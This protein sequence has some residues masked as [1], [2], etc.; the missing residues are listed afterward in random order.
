MFY[1]TLSAGTQI[2]IY[3]RLKEA[4]INPVIRKIF[5][6]WAVFWIVAGYVASFDYGNAE[7]DILPGRLAEI[8]RAC[9]LTWTIITVLT[10]GVLLLVW[11]C[12]GFKDFTRGRL[13]LAVTLSVIL[14]GYS[15]FEAYYVTPRY[16]EIRTPKLPEGTD[17]LRIAAVADAHIGGLATH[18]HFA[19]VKRL[20]DEA[21]PDIIALLGD[22]LDGLTRYR[23]RELVMLSG[24]AKNARLGA[25]AV[26]GNHEY[27]WLLDDDVEQVI[28]DCGYNL[29]INERAECAGIT[30]ISLDD[31]I[32]GWLKPYLLPEDSERFVL[33]LK[34][35]PGLPFDAQGK[36]DLQLSGHTHGGQFWPLGYFKSK[37]QNSTQGLSQKAGGY[38]YV[39][40]GSGFNGAMM[41]LFVPPEVTVIDL[42]R[43]D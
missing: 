7:Y 36:F 16:V 11:V 18:W 12:S 10:F 37:A 21:Q 38:V 35:R 2:L 14:T 15:M 17:R 26:N 4:G 9:S 24:M 32:R 27:Y 25:F 41:R 23:E 19:R 43:E 34:H 8:L 22:T 5:A 20:V 30:I 33:V 42:V 3:G 28:R 29:L 6:A 39:S 40:N 1:V 31:H 13:L